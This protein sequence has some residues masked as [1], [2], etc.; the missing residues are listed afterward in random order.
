MGC[1]QCTR[2]DNR[3]CDS[4]AGNHDRPVL[5]THD[6]LRPAALAE[7]LVHRRGRE[8]QRKRRAR[9][10]VELG[11]CLG[12]PAL[13][14]PVDLGNPNRRSSVQRTGRSRGLLGCVLNVIAPCITFF[15][16]IHVSLVKALY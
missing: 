8:V 11:H 14:C 10:L 13:V 7:V 6:A 12:L 5:G 16:Y 4:G 3:S 2:D 15:F 9:L 1:R